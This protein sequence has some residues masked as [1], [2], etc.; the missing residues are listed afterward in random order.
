MTGH[1]GSFRVACCGK[2]RGLLPGGVLVCPACDHAEA[3]TVPNGHLIR[4]VRP[5]ATHWAPERKA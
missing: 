1:D 5:D 3:S 4:G 2:R